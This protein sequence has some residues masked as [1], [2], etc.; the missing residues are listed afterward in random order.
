MCRDLRRLDFDR[1]THVGTVATK[2]ISCPLCRGREVELIICGAYRTAEEG[3]EAGVAPKFVSPCS[4]DN[5]W[6]SKVT[7]RAGHDVSKRQAVGLPAQNLRFDM[8]HCGAR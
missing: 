1:N 4:S 3:L 6:Q 8:R 7:Y 2:P 5:G